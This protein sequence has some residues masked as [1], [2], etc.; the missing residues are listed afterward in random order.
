MLP[1]CVVAAAGCLAGL[2]VGFASTA[3]RDRRGREAAAGRETHFGRIGALMHACRCMHG[4]LPIES[5]HWGVQ[6]KGCEADFEVFVGFNKPNKK[7]NRRYLYLHT[8][9]HYAFI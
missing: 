1:T 8:E 2:R 3:R 9:L 4:Y 7:L 5:R 6:T